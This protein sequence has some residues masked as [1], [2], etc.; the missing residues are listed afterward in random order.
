[1]RDKKAQF[2]IIS[3]IIVSFTLVGNQF[4]FA[5]YT[6]ADPSMVISLQEDYFFSD[7]KS[8][9]NATLYSS[10]C[11][12]AE[13]NLNEVK[14]DVEKRARERRWLLNMTF[15]DPCAGANEATKQS[16]SFF[17]NLTSFNYRLYDEFVL[18]P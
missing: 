8:A 2:F 18:L 1:M 4:L 5:G 17:V 11:P 15:T 10:P 3:T 9:A 12:V 16:T 13:R 6:Q 7:V 14:G